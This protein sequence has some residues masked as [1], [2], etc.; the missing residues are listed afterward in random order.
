MIPVVYYALLLI[1]A[2]TVVHVLMPRVPLY[3][4]RVRSLPLFSLRG[5]ELQTVIKADVLMQNDNFVKTDIHAI[6][7]DLYYP[8]WDGTLHHIGHVRDRAHHMASTSEYN[9]LNTTTPETPLWTMHARQ[10]FQTRDEVHLRV[11]TRTMVK[12]LGHLLWQLMRG[13]GLITVPSS[14]VAHVKS[15]SAK[16]TISMTCDNTLNALTMKLEGRQ[17]TLSKLASGWLDMDD[18]AD[19][20]RWQTLQLKPRDGSIVPE[21]I[22]RLPM[23]QKAIHQ[24]QM[25]AIF[26]V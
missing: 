1:P 10:S 8:T 19:R 21:K 2:L 5:G 25:D 22:K 7:F 16:V 12:S 11:P 26:F 4:F 24:E 23:L 13:G 15:S 3:E 9:T 18:E 14:G 20:M 6:A 17:C